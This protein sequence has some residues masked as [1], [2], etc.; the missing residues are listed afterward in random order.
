MLYDLLEKL[1]LKNVLRKGI[2]EGAI[3]TVDHYKEYDQ[4]TFWTSQE[5]S[6]YQKKA[7]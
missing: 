2:L 6:D 4:E 3:N 7:I 1:N 5:I